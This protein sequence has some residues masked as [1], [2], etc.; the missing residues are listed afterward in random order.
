MQVETLELSLTIT[1]TGQYEGLSFYNMAVRWSDGDN[2]I[3]FGSQQQDGSYL[4]KGLTASDFLLK[5]S[6]ISE[7]CKIDKIYFQIKDDEVLKNNL[8]SLYQQGT[9]KAKILRA[10]SEKAT[11]AVRL[12]SLF[13]GETEIEIKD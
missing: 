8:K 3:G 12:K 5:V 4:I 9:N 1:K 10:I 13:F 7:V 2:W 11:E 6:D